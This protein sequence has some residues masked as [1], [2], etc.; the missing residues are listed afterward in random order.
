VKTSSGNHGWQA[1][2]VMLL[3]MGTKNFLNLKF[4]A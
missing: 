3:L 1:L 2:I 4:L